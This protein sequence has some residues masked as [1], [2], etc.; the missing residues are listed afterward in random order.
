MKY[1]KI[2]DPNG[3]NGPIYHEGLNEDTLTFTPS[4]DCKPGGIYFAKEDI[5]AFLWE[6]TE[7]YEVKPVGPIYSDLKHPVLYKTRAAKLKYIGPIRDKIEFLL[8]Q[9]ANIHAGKDE[10]LIYA[11]EKRD[12]DLVKILVKHGANINARNGKPLILAWSYNLVEIIKILIKAGADPNKCWVWPLRKAIVAK[13]CEL[14]KFLIDHGADVN[15][16]HGWPLWRAL[17]SKNFKLV[18][19]L[20]EQGADINLALSNFKN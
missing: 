17:V 18:K 13:N 7:L 10:A 2:V 19:F 14:V 9:G 3:H 1:Y 4:G 5:L 11:I 12:I 20:I 15:T 16:D 8:R 6:G